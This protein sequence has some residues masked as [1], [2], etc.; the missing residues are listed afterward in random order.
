MQLSRKPSRIYSEVNPNVI[1]KSN[2]YDGYL[3]ANESNNRYPIKEYRSNMLQNIKSISANNLHSVVPKQEKEADAIS[4]TSSNTTT[5][6][7]G[8]WFIRLIDESLTDLHFPLLIPVVSL[9]DSHK[10][11]NKS[12]AI[13]RRSRQISILI[14]IMTLL[15]IILIAFMLVL[16]DMRNQKMPR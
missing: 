4:M 1:M 8:N 12:K 13:C 2:F 10:R 9:N 16:L 7:T 15:F 3:I 5:N 6:F 14:I 11:L